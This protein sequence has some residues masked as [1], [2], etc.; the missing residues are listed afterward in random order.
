MT[1]APHVNERKAAGKI[2]PDQGLLSRYPLIFFFIIA[3][4]G[5]WLVVL[6]YLRS[7]SGVGLCHLLG[8]CRSRSRPLLLPLPARS[9]PPSS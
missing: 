9:W 2:A 5:S 7:A 1:Q 4:A 3:C 6:P 8:R